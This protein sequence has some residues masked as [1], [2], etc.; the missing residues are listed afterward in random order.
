[1]ASKARPR[2]RHATPRECPACGRPG[3]LRG[4]SDAHHEGLRKSGSHPRRT[5]LKWY[6]KLDGVERSQLA[7]L[8]FALTTQARVQAHRLSSVLAV[9]E[10]VPRAMNHH[11]SGCLPVEGQWFFSHHFESCGRNQIRF[12][13]PGTGDYPSPRYL[14]R[15]AGHAVPRVRTVHRSADPLRRMQKVLALA[16]ARKVT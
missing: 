9:H 16:Q 14:R 3:A 10:G 2:S 8:G 6:E 7:F 11:S 13:N 5:L 15:A 4:S 1:M 12:Q